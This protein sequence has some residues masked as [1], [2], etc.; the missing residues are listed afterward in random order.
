MHKLIARSKADSNIESN[1][2]SIL[3]KLKQNTSL[4]NTRALTKVTK[5]NT[6]SKYI[7]SI[8]K[9]TDLVN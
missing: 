6:A 9:L 1:K 5:S 4:I 3:T 7:A 2:F 8:N